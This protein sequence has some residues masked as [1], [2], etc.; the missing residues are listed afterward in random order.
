MVG[1]AFEV[2]PFAMHLRLSFTNALPCKRKEKKRKIKQF[3][4][5][6]CPDSYA[7]INPTWLQQKDLE[8]CTLCE[9]N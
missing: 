3:F 8:K 6:S 4:E 1:N 7:H 5:H 2:M 9:M